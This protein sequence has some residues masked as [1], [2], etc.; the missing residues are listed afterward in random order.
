M[1]GNILN[2]ARTNFMCT[3]GRFRPNNDS[4]G[5]SQHLV[6]QWMAKE[7]EVVNIVM[8]IIGW[9]K[10]DFAG[11]VYWFEPE[12]YEIFRQRIEEFLTR[13]VVYEIIG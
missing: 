10:V 3:M 8:P 9:K 7:L 11:D 6:A 12:S 13:D 4:S 2:H 1:A 5:F